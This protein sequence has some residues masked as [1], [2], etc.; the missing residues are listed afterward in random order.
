MTLDGVLILVLLLAGTPG[1]YKPSGTRIKGPIEE[2]CIVA[3]SSWSRCT[4][5]VTL[6]HLRMHHSFGGGYFKLERNRMWI[7]GWV[8]D[9]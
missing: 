1:C 6:P 4:E 8:P 5:P 9:S 2:G 7:L 3:L